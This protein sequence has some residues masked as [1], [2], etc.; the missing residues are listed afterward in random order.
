MVANRERRRDRE[1]EKQKESTDAE[2]V[3]RTQ[4]DGIQNAREEKKR[5]PHELLKIF[6][7]YLILNFG[8]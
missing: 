7:I 1:R 3:Q 8:I 2:Y 4:R 5:N 6:R